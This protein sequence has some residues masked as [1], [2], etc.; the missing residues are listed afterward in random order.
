MIAAA[1]PVVR[2][3]HSYRFGFILIGCVTVALISLVALAVD[4]QPPG[5]G[6]AMMV[7]MFGVCMGPFLIGGIAIGL[8]GLLM[9]SPWY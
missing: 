9:C 8:V 4:S 3:W 6:L 5:S 1:S 7:S 2:R